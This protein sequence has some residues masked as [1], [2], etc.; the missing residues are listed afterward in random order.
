MSRLALPVGRLILTPQHL[1]DIAQKTRIAVSQDLGLIDAPLQK[2]NDRW[3]AGERFLEHVVFMGCSP[4][5]A[6]A[7]QHEN[8]LRFCHVRIPPSSTQPVL[9]RDARSPTPRCA[10][11]NQGLNDWF[12]GT[13]NDAHTELPDLCPHCKN[14]LSIEQIRWRKRSALS[15][16][17]IEIWNIFEREAVPA[18]ALLHGL[19]EA[20]GTV[21]SVS[22]ALG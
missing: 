8:D 14:R 20:T 11:C 5:I 3:H 10:Q 18:D 1:L 2:S 19:Q 17:R 9:S 15:L 22:Y 16:S 13:I 4:H 6:F 7:P 21:W 12:A